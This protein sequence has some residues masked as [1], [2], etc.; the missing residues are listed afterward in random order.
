MLEETQAVECVYLKCPQFLRCCWCRHAPRTNPH[1]SIGRIFST[2]FFT[3]TQQ[4]LLVFYNMLC[5]PGPVLCLRAL[6]LRIYLK[7]ATL[8]RLRQQYRLVLGTIG[9]DFEMNASLWNNTRERKPCGPLSG[10]L[11]SFFRSNRPPA[12]KD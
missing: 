10:F 9:T 11:S 3:E 4:F 1:P 6:F 12:R 5:G 2:M 8:L 7:A